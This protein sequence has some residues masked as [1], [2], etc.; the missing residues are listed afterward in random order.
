MTPPR[1]LL[2]AL[3]AALPGCA[4]AP[5]P[6]A[7]AADYALY[8]VWFEPPLAAPVAATLAHESG[9]SWRGPSSA[10]SVVFRAPE[11]P[12]TLSLRRAGQT[13]A[14]TSLKLSPSQPEQTWRRP[15]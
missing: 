8:T 6:A 2:L 4:Q 9:F 3:C 11:G 15:R 7:P 13:V 5:A 14:E 1:R 10:T 12:C